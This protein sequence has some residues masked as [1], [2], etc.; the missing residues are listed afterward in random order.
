[1]CVCVCVGRI[2]VC[3]EEGRSQAVCVGRRVCVWSRSQ[4]VCVGR[5]RVCVG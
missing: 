2:R 4:G 5:I 3:V 1:V